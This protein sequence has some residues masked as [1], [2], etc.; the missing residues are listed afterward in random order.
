MA[1]R[2]WGAVSGG[3]AGEER[4]FLGVVIEGAAL[5]VVDEEQNVSVGLRDFAAVGAMT[6]EGAV[7]E[8]R[9]DVRP[10]AGCPCY[11]WVIEELE[12]RCA[13]LIRHEEGAE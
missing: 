5:L 4:G 12:V 3:N 11:L 6:V 10:R 1:D 9:K 13:V 2:E 7:R 8:F